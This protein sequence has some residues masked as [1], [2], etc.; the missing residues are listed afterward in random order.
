M[1]S[2]LAGW[3]SLVKCDRQNRKSAYDKFITLAF[4]LGKS[5]LLRR[6]IAPFL[7]DWFL[8]LPWVSSRP[9]ADL[10][11]YINTL[12]S[13]TKL[14][15]KF[16]HMLAGTLGL[17]STLFLRGVLDNSLGFVKTLLG[18]FL[19]ST[20]SWST[21]LP[22]LLGTSG[23]GSVLLDCLLGYRADF[24]GPLGALGVGGVA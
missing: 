9:G 7:N 19:E 23:D 21:D 6:H 3:L 15:H 16:G 24:L 11:G 8:D 12:L 14:G 5:G 4:D 17:K 10:L 20:T 18:T 22:W 1:N 13:R 2:W